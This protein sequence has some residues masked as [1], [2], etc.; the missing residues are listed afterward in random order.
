MLQSEESNTHLQP[1]NH[2]QRTAAESIWILG[3]GQFGLHAV[4][5]LRHNLPDADIILVEKEKLA[6]PPKHVTLVNE[7]GVAWLTRN[8]T[9][10]TKVTRIVPALPLHLATEWLKQLLR[11]KGIPWRS[12]E[13]PDELLSCLPHP[14]RQSPSQAVISHADFICPTHCKEPEK[15]C[16]YT[17]KERPRALYEMIE[18]L[19]Y[20][21]FTPLVIRSRQFAHGVGGFFPED[22]WNLSRQS[23][24]ISKTPLL[25]A[26]ACKCH[27]IIDGLIIG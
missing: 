26:T 19:E 7:D 27:G 2:T 11:E 17:G 4:S 3:G 16:T 13:I 14:L 9:A 22:L 20:A 23:E 21:P 15:M 18:N 24:S 10:K 1:E 8:L 25:I 6:K 12:I 5:V